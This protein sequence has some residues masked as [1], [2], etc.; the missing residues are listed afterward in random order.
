MLATVEKRTISKEGAG[1]EKTTYQPTIRLN[2]ERERKEPIL[3]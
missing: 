3:Q 1:N 2:P